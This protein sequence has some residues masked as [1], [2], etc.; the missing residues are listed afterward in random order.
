MAD[1][2]IVIASEA[3]RQQL[4]RFLSNQPLDKPLEIIW[5]PFKSKR[6]LP[7]NA[8]FHKWVSVLARHFTKKGH[9]VSDD[10]M[11][12]LLKHQFLGYE[13]ITVGRTEIKDQLRHTS[14]LN[15][16]EF[17]E[18]MTKVDAWAADHGCFL[19]RPEDS[20]YERYLSARV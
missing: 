12:L 15:S 19:P 11:K 7:A 2:R 18:F 13:S 8:L 16:A 14:K 17:C 5:R 3:Q 1:N 4:I 9:Q 6:S 20:E 10:Y